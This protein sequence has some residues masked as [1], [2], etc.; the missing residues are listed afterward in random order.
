MPKKGLRGRRGQKRKL[1]DKEYEKCKL[2]AEESKKKIKKKR[3]DKAKEAK[4]AIAN[5]RKQNTEKPVT[6][7]VTETVSNP[8]SNSVYEAPRAASTEDLRKAVLPWLKRQTSNK[9]WNSSRGKD[10]RGE[11]Y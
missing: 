2:I 6:D 1:S 9:I 3:E 11:L 4:K 10:R 7:T 5:L 8:V